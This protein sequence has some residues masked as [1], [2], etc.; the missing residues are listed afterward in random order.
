MKNTKIFLILIVTLLI[1][2]STTQSEP[3]IDTVTSFLSDNAGPLAIGALGLASA[4]LFYKQWIHPYFELPPPTGPYKVGTSTHH[5]I[6]TSRVDPFP[7]ACGAQR[8]LIIQCWYPCQSIKNNVYPYMP[9][10]LPYLIK[11]MEQAYGIQSTI[12]KPFFPAIYKHAIPDAPIAYSD[13]LFPVVLFNHGYYSLCDLNTTQIE[14][15]ASH[16][17]VVVGTNWTYNSLVNIF[18]DGKVI[19]FDPE[20]RPEL[21]D[22][23]KFSLYTGVDDTKFVLN[24]LE[25]L[26]TEHP[27]MPI[28]NAIDLERI[29]IL[30][31]CSGGISLLNLCPQEPRIKAA[32][33]LDGWEDLLAEELSKPQTIPIM[34]IAKDPTV[35]LSRPDENTQA[36]LGLYNATEKDAYHI[37]IKGTRHN[38]FYDLPFIKK[39]FLPFLMR[40]KLKGR[41]M[42]DPDKVNNL[43]RD[44]VITF[45]DKYLKGIDTSWPEPGPDYQEFVVLSK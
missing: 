32:I 37:T 22:E 44:C 38:D 12:L 16:G 9:D 6:D 36:L 43:M 25:R 5:W 17:Y 35:K 2:T 15:L 18:P 20:L 11:M 34:H 39:N 8:E 40:N 7:K 31:Y 1:H 23:Y 10:K 14:N 41:T 45:F 28:T 4:G 19:Q 29:G 13:K 21:E 42:L 24:T 3:F 30:G 33:N 26:E 27:T